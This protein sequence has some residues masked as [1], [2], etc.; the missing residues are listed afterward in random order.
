MWDN[1]KRERTEHI[2]SIIENSIFSFKIN[3]K[4]KRL[5]FAVLKREKTDFSKKI[6]LKYHEE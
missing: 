1:K 5:E 4:N 6:D 3:K 2:K